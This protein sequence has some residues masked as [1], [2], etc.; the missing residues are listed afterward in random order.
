[1]AFSKPQ[2]RDGLFE[3]AFRTKFSGAFGLAV[4]LEAVLFPNA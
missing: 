1:M 2:T 4:M 3:F